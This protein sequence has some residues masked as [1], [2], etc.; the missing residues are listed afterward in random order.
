MVSIEFITVAEDGQRWKISLLPGHYVFDDQGYLAMFM[1]P[2]T[3]K[4]L[5]LMHPEMPNL[6]PHYLDYASK[7]LSP[8]PI[9]AGSSLAVIGSRFGFSGAGVGA[10]VGVISSFIAREAQTI[11]FMTQPGYYAFGL[12][13]SSSV[14]AQRIYTTPVH[15][16]E[17]QLFR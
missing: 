10:I 1:D 12:P 17:C 3:K 16:R 14:S 13:S 2:N 7:L 4:F 9:A 6:W 8:H 15:L 5:S 11:K